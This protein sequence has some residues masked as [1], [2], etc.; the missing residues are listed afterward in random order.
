MGIKGGVLE[1]INV[2]GKTKTREP[3]MY[4][5]VLHNDDFTPKGFV[6]QLLIDL[7]HKTSAEAIELM[8]HVHRGDKGIAGI[9]PREIAET[10]METGIALARGN[11]FPLQISIEPDT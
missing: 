2:A 5:V 9:Y 6:V 3:P 11:G 10:K 8:W 1:K 7:F 4:R